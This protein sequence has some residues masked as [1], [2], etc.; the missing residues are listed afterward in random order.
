MPR[1][2]QFICL[3]AR[4]MPI[5]GG[6]Q[7][8]LLSLTFVV[9]LCLSLEQSRAEMVGTPNI[10]I[11]YPDDMGYGDPGVFGG[12]GYKTP[13]IDRLA[14]EGRRFTDFYVAQPVCSA[15]RTAL[16]TG[17]YPNRLGIH[18]AL[19]PRDKVGISDQEVTLAEICRSR[20][21]AT[22]IFGK[23]HLGCQEQFLP[24]QHGFDEFYG[25]PYSNDMW[26][27]HPEFAN[28]GNDEK[29]K[30]FPTL[31]LYDGNKVVNAEVTPEDQKVFTTEFTRRAI[32]FIERHKDRPFFLYLPHPQ[33]HVPL[34]VSDKFRGKSERG[35]YGDVMMEIDWSVGE[36]ISALKRN[37]VDQKTLVIFATDNGPWLS[38]GDHAGT[39]AGLRE[40]KGTT[41]E[42]GVRVP[43]IMKWP[44][45]LP[46]GSICHEPMMTIDL[47]PTIAAII[48]APLPDHKIDG[49]N[50]WPVVMG[51]ANAKCPHAAY[52][53]YYHVN[54]L[55][56]MRSG[57]WKLH[58]PHEFRTLVGKGG[59][60]GQPAAYR[61]ATIG[62]E[63]FDLE[64]DPR[65][66]SNVASKHPEVVE[67]LRRL[68]DD[69]REDLGDRLTGATG[70]GSRSPGI[71][72]EM[73]SAG[74]GAKQSASNSSVEIH[75]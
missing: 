42:G 17:C 54:D 71:Y 52:F 2:I 10:V 67:R 16:L 8:C 22:G 25:I 20:G 62:L 7:R 48:G 32:Q 14:Q 64:Q 43:C 15:S 38:Y 26:P 47:L 23:W 65:E 9:A 70:E 19:G 44:G 49:L 60:N 24:L 56:A 34:F 13:N 61:Q 21:Y 37:G 33:P 29:K 59:K 3:F 58:F 39:T 45:Q 5:L 51:E 75:R 36:V 72:V 53:F 11:I 74:E 68:A 28:R 40:G 6:S 66:T 41:F 73:D 30:G 57:R 63:L 27:F 35:L 55:E 69:M 12:R 18:G 50:A 46:A 1:G 4:S 31:P